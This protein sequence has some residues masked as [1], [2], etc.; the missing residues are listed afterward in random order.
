MGLSY[1][2]K[3]AL[4]DI[5]ILSSIK[6]MLRLGMLGLTCPHI[7]QTLVDSLG[8][9]G[10][11]CKSFSELKGNDNLYYFVSKIPYIPY[12]NSIRLLLFVL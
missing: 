6:Q 1:L 3:S 9:L 4:T 10:R 7:F 8:L 2:R 5:E 12:Y 11:I